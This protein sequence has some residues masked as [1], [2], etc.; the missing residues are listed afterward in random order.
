LK[1]QSSG[2]AGDGRR[3]K[4]RPDLLEQV[5]RD[6]AAIR[7]A[8]R[9]PLDSEIARGELTPPQMAIMRWVVSHEGASVKELSHAAGLAHSTVSSIID[10]LVKRGMLER[11]AHPTDGRITRIHSSA[12]VRRFIAERLPQLSRSPLE[13]ALGR[14][15]TSEQAE[16][17]AAVRR[18]RQLLD[19]TRAEPASKTG[20][21]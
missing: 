16:I 2:A 15:S 9:V 3:N 7:R 20:P 10:R 6:L 1:R 14:A 18:L 8:L 11:R 5:Q 21:A 12:V 17:G 4:P 13:S 19:E